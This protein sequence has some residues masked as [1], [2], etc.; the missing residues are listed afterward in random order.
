MRI[1]LIFDELLLSIHVTLQTIAYSIISQK[2][3]ETNFFK[4]LYFFKYTVKFYALN[5]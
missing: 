5:L 2:L 1:Y 4:F 3:G